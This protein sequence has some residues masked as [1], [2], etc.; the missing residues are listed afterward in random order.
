MNH[1]IKVYDNPETFDRY[2][3]VI[4]NDVYSMS[5]NPSDPQGFNQY[6]FTIDDVNKAK[7]GWMNELNYENIGKRVKLTQ[8][9]KEVKKAIKERCKDYFDDLKEYV[10]DIIDQM[11]KAKAYSSLGIYN[12]TLDITQ[13]AIEFQEISDEASLTERQ[14]EDLINYA[15]NYAERKFKNVN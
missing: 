12:G 8:L 2:T 11:F 4:D 9:P 7:N 13:G 1:K 14:H 15:Q 5:E 10:K 3:I 6:N